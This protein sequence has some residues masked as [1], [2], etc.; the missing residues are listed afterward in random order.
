MSEP[1]T[2]NRPHAL[3]IAA[4]VSVLLMSGLGI[5]RILDILPDNQ[6]NAASIS[7]DAEARELADIEAKEKA[8]LARK[9]LEDQAESERWRLA[10]TQPRQAAKHVSTQHQTITKTATVCADCGVITAIAEQPNATGTPA[11]GLGAITGAVIGGVLGNQ[12]GKG[13][14]RRV[15]RI[16]GA[17]G[18]AYAG[19]KV[20]GHVRSGSSYVVTVR[21][22]DGREEQ[23][24]YAEK[25]TAFIGMTVRSESG[26][27]VPRG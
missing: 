26:Q 14:G 15:A 4:A 19:H 24:T 1:T 23:F 11:T 27:L 2:T 12:I 10:E 18:G 8:A 22:D 20:E 17:I 5:A 25:P 13:D 9:A 6:A 21:F 7:A 16:A 3:V